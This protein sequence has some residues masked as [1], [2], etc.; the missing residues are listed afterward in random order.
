[1]TADS[2]FV[3]CEK[4]GGRTIF[5]TLIQPLGDEPGHRIYTCHAC[6]RL[7]WVQWWGWQPEPE[8]QP[9]R[10]PQEQQQQQQQQQQQPQ[11]MPDGSS[12]Q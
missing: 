2:P 7:T 11:K 8:P 5:T 6:K 12:G 10:A 9:P 4:C 1:M 3:P